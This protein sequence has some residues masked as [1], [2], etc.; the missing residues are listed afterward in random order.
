[1]NTLSIKRILSL[2]FLS[3]QLFIAA[4]TQN[5]VDLIQ[6][7]L[8]IDH[9]NHNTAQRA[10]IAYEEELQKNIGATLS[11]RTRET[12]VYHGR[13]RNT[14]RRERCDMNC[15]ETRALSDIDLE[16]MSYVTLNVKERSQRVTNLQLNQR[17]LSIDNM[18]DNYR[19]HEAVEQRIQEMPDSESNMFFENNN[20]NNNNHRRSKREIFNYDTRFNIIKSRQDR[21]P[22]TTVVKLSTGCSGHIVDS[23]H[24]LTAAHCIHDGRSYVKGAKKLRVGR[25]RGGKSS[26]RALKNPNRYFKWKPVHRVHFPENWKKSGKSGE[27]SI[28]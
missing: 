11:R 1:M 14:H 25:P 24:I 20:N 13:V 7:S 10:K 2:L 19:F 3:N 26:G 17:A 21:Y 28:I 16:N 12:A 8:N 4:S 27:V 18:I 22:F 15:H 6:Q 5:F 9:P 23:S